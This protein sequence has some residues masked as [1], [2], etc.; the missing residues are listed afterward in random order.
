MRVIT[1]SRQL[2]SEGLPVARRVAEVLGYQC[3]DRAIVSETAR[4]SDIPEGEVERHDER[5]QN[6]IERVLTHIFGGPSSAYSLG[7]MG[8][9]FGVAMVPPAMLNEIAQSRIPDREDIISTIE[10]IIKTAAR[11]GSVV[12]IGRGSQ[13]LLKDGAEVLHV[14][15][16][17]PPEVRI[18]RIA[19]QEGI[20]EEEAGNLIRETDQSRERYIRQH[21]GVDWEDAGLYHLIVN[22]GR[23]GVEMAARVIAEA[24][25]RS[26]THTKKE[27]DALPPETQEEVVVKR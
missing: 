5:G 26:K 3:L 21:Y 23:T 14:R 1:I 8:G 2:G 27:L 15:L 11:R 16:M 25:R 19:A 10:D 24:A 18:Q 6:L 22:T 12:I 4:M 17:A 9:E 7:A 13:A 20:S